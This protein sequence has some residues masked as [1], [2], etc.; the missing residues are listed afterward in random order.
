M[1]AVLVKWK[2][3]RY[4]TITLEQHPYKI[5]RVPLESVCEKW[6]SLMGWGNRLAM[7]EG[8]DISE[9]GRYQENVKTVASS[10][11]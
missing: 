6:R 8:E 9:T 10:I 3:E 1:P 2:S 5:L 4:D 7:P 11:G